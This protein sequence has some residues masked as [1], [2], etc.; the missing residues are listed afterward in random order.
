MDIFLGHHKTDKTGLY[1]KSFLHVLGLFLKVNGIFLG[2]AKFQ[3]ILWAC[4]TFLVFVLL[5]SRCLVQ[6]YVLR[7]IESTPP[8]P[9]HPCLARICMSVPICLSFCMHTETR[10]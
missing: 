5:N 1:L 3:Q 7:I 9:V 2:A 10:I 8:G 4:L 6:A